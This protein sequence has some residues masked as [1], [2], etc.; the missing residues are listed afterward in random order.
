MVPDGNELFSL[1]QPINRFYTG[2]VGALEELHD[3]LQSRFIDGGPQRRK[4][5]FV[6]GEG[7]SG[8][9]QLCSQFAQKNRNRYGFLSMS[10][11]QG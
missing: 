6:V 1:P 11:F 7:G 2:R 3:K 4:I 10:V 5:V 9:T 8:K